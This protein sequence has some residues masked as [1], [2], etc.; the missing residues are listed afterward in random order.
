MRIFLNVFRHVLVACAVLI[1]PIIFSACAKTDNHIHEFEPATIQPTCARLGHT[2]QKCKHCS[3]FI[4]ETNIEKLEHNIVFDKLII[5]H[6]TIDQCA[7]YTCTS[8]DL[9]EYKEISSKELGIPILAFHGSLKGISK[10]NKITI[11]ATY[12]NGDMSFS[13]DATLKWQGASS[14]SYPKKNFN[15]QF[16]QTGTTKKNK[17][18]LCD[19]WGKQ[20]KYT[21]KAN[22]IDYSQARNVVSGQI[23]EQIVHSRYIDDVVSKT[24]NGG[25]VDGFPIVIYLNGDFYGLYTLNIPKDNWMFGMKDDDPDDEIVTKHAAI[26]TDSWAKKVYLVDEI[27]EHS[28]DIELEFC[29]TEDTIGNDWV[30]ESFNDMIN[31]INHSTDQEFKSKISNYVNL[32]RTIDSMIYTSAIMAADNTAKNIIWLTYDGQHWFSSMYDMDST[33]GLYWT[34][35]E[36]YQPNKTIVSNTDGNYLWQ[37]IYRLYKTEISTR[38]FELRSNILSLENINNQFTHFNNLIPTCVRTVEKEKWTKVPSQKTNNIVQIITFAE[39]RFA[40]LDNIML[41]YST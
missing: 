32:E 13:S 2:G 19:D 35:K 5:D 40:Y 9:K 15:I 30:L 33:W 41:N 12:T 20:S 11:Q 3:K 25:V 39:Q 1:V 4:V 21:L 22:Y 8:C 29:S 36:Y 37:R 26:S 24:A 27:K 7:R 17:V 23:Y 31:F 34:G 14:L 16:L 28:D 18:A 38:Y 6:K 10:S